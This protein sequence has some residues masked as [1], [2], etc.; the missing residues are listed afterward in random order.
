M[1]TD[2]IG[3]KVRIVIYNKQNEPEIDM[4]CRKLDN[5]IAAL[6]SK[7]KFIGNHK[8]K[9]TELNVIELLKE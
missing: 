2:Y 8:T 9:I 3:K 7:Y 6:F 4:I 5:D 1:L